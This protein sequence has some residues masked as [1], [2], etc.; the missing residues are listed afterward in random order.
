MSAGKDMERVI[1]MGT[2]T[3]ADSGRR[4][5]RVKHQDTGMTSGWLKVVKTSEPCP[6]CGHEPWFPKVN[7]TVLAMYL[8]TSGGDGF[9]IG[10]V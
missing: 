2:V 6:T 1:Q 7:D 9:V 8:P 4:M 10:G 5:V 3:D